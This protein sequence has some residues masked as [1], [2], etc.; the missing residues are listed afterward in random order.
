MAHEVADL[1]NTFSLEL[2][3]PNSQHFIN[4]QNFARRWAATAN[5]SRTYIPLL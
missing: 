4:Y 5:A 3:V 1:A 2:S